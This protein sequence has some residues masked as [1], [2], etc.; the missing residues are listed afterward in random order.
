[1]LLFPYI[2]FEI[3]RFKIHRV[4]LATTVVVLP[5]IKEGLILLEMMN[6]TENHLSSE[7]VTIAVKSL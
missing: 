7:V 5:I 6:L 1:M 4:G 3:V 2:I